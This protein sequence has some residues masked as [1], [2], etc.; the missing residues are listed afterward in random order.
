MV[1]DAIKKHA[2]LCEFLGLPIP[3]AFNSFSGFIHLLLKAPILFFFARCKETGHSHYPK[4][5]QQDIGL[6]LFLFQSPV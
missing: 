6:F 2:M 1:K 3:R 4:T 5:A